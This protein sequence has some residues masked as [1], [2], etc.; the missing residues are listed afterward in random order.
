M[1]GEKSVSPE[2]LVFDILAIIAVMAGAGV[3]LARNPVHSAMA[4][5]VTFV[6]LAGIFVLLRAEFLAAVQIIVYTGA[7]LV[8]V[9]FVIMLVDQDDLPEFHG[10]KPVQRVMGLLIGLMLLGEVAAAVLTRTVVGQPGPWTEEAVLAAGGN[11][12]VLGQFM[13]SGW[14]LPVQTIAVVLLVGTIGALVLARPDASPATPRGR[15]T[16]TI[17]LGHPRG[18]DGE[19]SLPLP[20]AGDMA[21]PRRDPRGE[22]RG[23]LV[24]VK[25]NE[26]YSDVPA[27]DPDD[28]AGSGSERGW[29]GKGRRDE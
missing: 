8:I 21:T 28:G 19:L 16:Q 18:A 6:N 9:L 17:S 4:L 11:V 2:V 22:R 24:M 14:V 25:D 13:Y 10:G 7:I 3:V 23:G 12:Q 26:S 27:W 5:V 20:K 15:T 1:E 29:R